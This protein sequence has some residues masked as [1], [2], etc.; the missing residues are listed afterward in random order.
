MTILVSIYK[1]VNEI[2]Y[3]SHPGTGRRHFSTHLFYAWLVTN[4][5]IYELNFEAFSSLGMV[6][7]SGLGQAKSFQLKEARELIGF[8][9]GFH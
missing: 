1:G 3:S 9:R 2:P 5:D 7:F 4:F 6:K 8:G